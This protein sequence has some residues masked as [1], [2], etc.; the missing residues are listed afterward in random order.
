MR[1][2]EMSS[3]TPF[4]EPGSSFTPFKKNHQACMTEH[5]L[6]TFWAERKGICANTPENVNHLYPELIEGLNS[7]NLIDRRSG[8]SFSLSQARSVVPRLFIS[9]F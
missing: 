5:T 1:F 3:L 2:G 7:P 9:A 6:R 4:V 8:I